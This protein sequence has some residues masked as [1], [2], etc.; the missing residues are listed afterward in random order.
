MA[1]GNGNG[2]GYE[3]GSDYVPN[4]RTTCLGLIGIAA[5]AVVV[6]DFGPIVT[7]I[8]GCFASFAN[9][10]GLLLARDARAARKQLKGLQQ[11]AS[12]NTEIVNNPIVKP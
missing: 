6:A 11:M 1:N 5:G 2:N 12:G 10:A 4:W 3:N 7:K 8:A 9:S